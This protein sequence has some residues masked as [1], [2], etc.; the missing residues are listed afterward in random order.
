MRSRLARYTLIAVGVLAAIVIFLFLVASPVPMYAFYKT[1]PAD[2]P[3]VIAHQGGDGVWP[4]ESMLAYDESA[5]LGVDVLEGDV[6]MTKDGVLVLMH[7]DTV[8]RTTDGSGAISDMTLGQIKQL[9]AA[10]D[11][12]PD[13]GKT[14]PYR[15]QGVQVTTVEE[16]FKAH[17]DRHM[18]LEIK[19]VTPSIAT[20]FCEL[21]AKYNM[22]D[23]V[24]VASFKTEAMDEFR[25]VCPQIATSAVED[26]VRLFFIL[27]TIFLGGAYSPI[28]TAMQVPE[29]SG[30]LHVLT[31][32]FIATA[33]R[34]GMQ[35]HV[36]T[37]NEEADM[38]RMIDLGVDGIIT[39]RP[40]RLMKL[41]GR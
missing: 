26:E 9:D 1:L 34:R 28:E 22:Q 11:W 15:G 27:N 10:Y 21:I 3:L 36:W 35:V 18:N 14:F 32:G 33:H 12:S 39:D 2:R 7:D 24:L 19:Q 4:G 8:D 31:P 6:H 25:R 30:S 29:T 5:R 38:Q 41:L 20:P 23:R 37:V 16:L 40:D 17:A 13:D